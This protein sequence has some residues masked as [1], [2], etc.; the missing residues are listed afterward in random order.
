MAH[1]KH[2]ISAY[3]DKDLS[4]KEVREVESHVA[5]CGACRQELEEIKNAVRLLQAE[6]KAELPAGYLQRL[7]QKY[8]KDGREKESASPFDFPYYKLAAFALTGLMVMVAVKGFHKADIPSKDTAVSEEA[9]A[10][11]SP[12]KD[13]PETHQMDDRSKTG[14]G[15][16]MDFRSRSE[17]KYA[18]AEVDNKM[19]AEGESLRPMAAQA[20]RMKDEPRLDED[21]LGKSSSGMEAAVAFAKTYLVRDELTLEEKIQYTEP[22]KSKSSKFAAEAREPTFAEKE[23]GHRLQESREN[24][25]TSRMVREGVY[26]VTRKPQYQFEVN[27]KQGTIKGLN[28]LSVDIL[29]H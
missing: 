13:A 22:A 27:L 8:L 2:L 1:V 24:V 26:E 14:S 25:W 6:P 3:L 11:R 18:P 20:G 21:S 9:A 12:N 29:K 28:P 23:A 16:K 19:T 17:K 4:E 5:Q 7:D 10:N 15:S